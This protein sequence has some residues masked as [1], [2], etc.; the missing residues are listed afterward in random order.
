MEGHKNQ[1]KYLTTKNINLSILIRMICFEEFVKQRVKLSQKKN[2][3]LII[4][5]EGIIIIKKN[6]IC[7]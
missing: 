1:K 5:K 4:K 2:E 3:E 6:Y 7:L